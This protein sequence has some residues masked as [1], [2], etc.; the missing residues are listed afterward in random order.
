MLSKFGSFFDDKLKKAYK[1]PMKPPWNPSTGDLHYDAGTNV[2]WCFSVGGWS[3]VEN[4]TPAQKGSF[5]AS[6]EVVRLDGIERVEKALSQA[7]MKRIGAG[8]VVS[9]HYEMA[10]QAYVVLIRQTS[11][12]ISQKKKSLKL[13]VYEEKLAHYSQNVPLFNAWI[14]DLCDAAK[15]LLDG[16]P[17]QSW[18]ADPVKLEAEYVERAEQ[19]TD[20]LVG[21]GAHFVLLQLIGKHKLDVTEIA[22]SKV[23]DEFIAHIKLGSKGVDGQEPWD[24]E[25]TYGVLLDYECLRDHRVRPLALLNDSKQVDSETRDELYRAVIACAEVVAVISDVTDPDQPTQRDLRMLDLFARQATAARRTPL[26]SA[27]AAWRWPRKAN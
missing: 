26:A 16:T 6:Q 15:V 9:S 3:K 12:S 25:E 10:R 21:F 18:G 14:N 13:H 22:L 23:T 4:P 1:V 27:R 24:L 7:L 8:W 20:Q 5:A 17:V 2:M 11:L 19:A